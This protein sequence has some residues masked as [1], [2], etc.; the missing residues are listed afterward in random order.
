MQIEVKA[1]QTVVL[2]IKATSENQEQTPPGSDNSDSTG[3]GS[4]TSGGGTS[5]GGSSDCNL[6]QGD[7]I[8]KN[9]NDILGSSAINN[10]GAIARQRTDI[11]TTYWN[12]DSFYQAYIPLS[13][14]ENCKLI[15]YNKLNVYKKNPELTGTNARR[16][17]QEFTGITFL[18]FLSKDSVQ[19]V[20]ALI[21]KI[22][23]QVRDYQSYTAGGR[24]LYLRF[25]N[26]DRS[27]TPGN[28]GDEEMHY[29]RRTGV[30]IVIPSSA[31]PSQL[32][33]VIGQKFRIHYDT[34]KDNI[35]EMNRDELQQ[36]VNYIQGNARRIKRIFISGHTDDTNPNGNQQLSIDRACNVLTE[37]LRI[38][39]FRTRYNGEIGV[40]VS[41]RS[42]IREGRI[43]PD[44]QTIVVQGS[45]E[46][47][48]DKFVI[49]TW[50][51]EYDPVISP[52]G[53]QGTALDNS[54]AANRRVEVWVI[55]DYEQ[56]DS[57]N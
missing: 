43:S 55:W 44:K 51:R 36:I 22:H 49:V 46:G 50:H 57:A 33:V 27:G 1:G 4:G 41:C 3:L 40:N 12:N 34:G 23:E 39:G 37:L 20:L 29:V 18:G 9:I 24:E 38:S 47:Q 35:I 7:F 16:Y 6:T 48:A 54:R 26:V 28:L 8:T 30:D 2:D 11:E 31:S 42:I 45:S 56:W 13:R 10:H 5:S 15:I 19:L 21:T 25:Q 32:E 53:L 17:Y 52:Q 14:I